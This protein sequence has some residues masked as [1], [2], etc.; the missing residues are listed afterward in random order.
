MMS[1][2][3]WKLNGKTLPTPVIDSEFL[4]PQEMV[5]TFFA[6]KKIGFVGLAYG[7]FKEWQ[8]KHPQWNLHEYKAKI[9]HA[10]VHISNVYT[11]DVVYPSKDL[12]EDTAKPLP[13]GDSLKYAGTTV[14]HL[15]PGKLFLGGKEIGTVTNFSMEMSEKNVKDKV[16]AAYKGQTYA[17]FESVPPKDMNG[18]PLPYVLI[19]NP[20][21][22]P[23]D[24]EP[25][26]V[27]SFATEQ[28]KWGFIM[29][30]TKNGW[31]ASKNKQGE[32][33]LTY[34][35]SNNVKVDS[36]KWAADGKEPEWLAHDFGKGIGDIVEMAI[37]PPSPED[38]QAVQLAAKVVEPPP[39]WGQPKS[40]AE[41]VS[42]GKP[43]G[44]TPD[45]K[46]K[47]PKFAQQK[48]KKYK[49]HGEVLEEQA[50]AESEWAV[51]AAKTLGLIPKVGSEDPLEKTVKPKLFI[52]KHLPLQEWH[53]TIVCSPHDA[54]KSAISYVAMAEVFPDLKTGPSA[55]VLQALFFS[56]LKSFPDIQ[57]AKTLMDKL[58]AVMQSIA[59]AKAKT[60][61]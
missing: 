31:S 27:K 44:M 6:A 34:G 17:V 48:F 52:D 15:G 7:T 10:G 3:E 24:S 4:S 13:G 42:M 45:D 57:D 59:I 21:S 40:V 16:D 12:L 1:N 38:H 5:D 22:E 61:K 14:G 53:L 55:E 11:G 50:K 25:L 46:M 29:Q 19:K 56:I 23:H 49:S 47:Y 54:Y 51:K 35:S 32:F 20:F 37:N 36:P 39:G 8:S 43:V 18:T 2:P 26:E 60:D 28:D 9:G 33:V 58:H 41:A 30:Q